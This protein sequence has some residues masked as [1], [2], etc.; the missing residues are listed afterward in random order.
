MKE[1]GKIIGTFLMALAL[2]S[3]AT[4]NISQIDDSPLGT[5]DNKA[6]SFD[7]QSVPKIP[8]KNIFNDALDNEEKF[9]SGDVKKYIRLDST[10]PI[11]LYGGW[12]DTINGNH[13]AINFEK[14]LLHI[15]IS[16]DILSNRLFI[17]GKDCDL[18][19]KEWSGTLD[20]PILINFKT[21]RTTIGS[22]FKII[23]GSLS[24]NQFAF[25]LKMEDS[26]ILY[27]GIF[28]YEEKTDT[29]LAAINTIDSNGVKKRVI[30][31]LSRNG[32]PLL[33]ANTFICPDWLKDYKGDG[34]KI[35]TDFSDDGFKINLKNKDDKQIDISFYENNMQPESDKIY[36]TEDKIEIEMFKNE[37]KENVDFDFFY[38]VSDDT[39]L[40][41]GIEQNEKIIS[42]Q[43]KEKTTGR[44]G[45]IQGN[46]V[47]NQEPIWRMYLKNEDGS[48]IP[49]FK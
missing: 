8:V 29:I 41:D 37:I 27:G 40:I 44:G 30:Y 3:C 35:K 46:F 38:I 19:Q 49:F 6:S 23:Y 33:A 13:L 2:T 15:F 9:S 1:I 26:G 14:G 22:N 11:Y 7:I 48:F 25:E 31:T 42:I 28:T 32:E 16:N 36:S 10:I 39:T 34:K 4:S 45:I 43:I 17:I 24:A 21:E 18:V 12:K 5:V 47:E 20:N